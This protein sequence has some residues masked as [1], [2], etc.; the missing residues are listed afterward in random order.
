MLATRDGGDVLELGAGIYS[1]PILHNLC[2]AQG[3]KMVTY[4]SDPDF[5]E[6]AAHYQ[7]PFHDVRKVERWSDIDISMPWAV[8][9]VD[10]A[11]DDKRWEDV[12]R[13]AHAEYVV[14][15]DSD[16]K[17]EHKYRFSKAYPLFKYVR[18][19]RELHP[20]TAVLSNLHALE[21]LW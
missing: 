16:A 14:I 9:F 5:Y 18:Q 7:T 13:L 11:P 2:D 21:G 1:T 8:A 3:R 15:H 6:W 20:N 10:H 19:Y 12:A 17:W 4:E